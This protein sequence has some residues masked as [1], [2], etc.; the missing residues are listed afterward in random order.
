V[1]D[2]EKDVYIS[3]NSQV[4]FQIKK[5][6]P[7]LDVECWTMERKNKSEKEILKNGVKFRVFPSSLSIRHG[8]ELSKS[9][10]LALIKEIKKAEKNKI[11]LVIHFHEYHSWQ[12]YLILL[13]LKKKKNIKIIGQHH[14]GR[15]PFSN[16]FKYKRLFLFLPIIILMQ[17][18]ENLLFKK[19][20][21]FYALGDKEIEY[22]KRIAPKS[23]IKFQ[24]MGIDEKYFNITGKNLARK[25]LGLKINQRYV[26]YIGRIKT[27]KGIKELLDA[28]K[29]I[30]A[31]LLLIG[32]GPDRNKYE[33][34]AQTENI[35]N[36]QFLGADYSDRKLDYLSACDCLILPSYTEGAPVV[37]MEAV[38]KNLPV[39]ATDVGGVKKMIENG[40][41][42]L[43]IKPR[44]KEDIKKAINEILNWKKK[45]I[46]EYA[47]KYKWAQ[48]IKETINDYENDKNTPES[49]NNNTCL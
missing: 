16:L 12:V 14:G 35:K 34:Y 15:S 27:T 7:D 21:I 17:F 39:I 18:F 42:G 48:I 10:L 1:V 5:F 3:W 29:E 13:L 49:I 24:T 30:N 9:M 46:Q 41:E 33:Y 2:Y 45:N 8:M 25:N 36:I 23:K 6:D 40:K 44:S 47:K 19:I 26:L 32:D 28:M 37:L 43:I 11:K 20:D 4:S 22:L 31:E 38:A